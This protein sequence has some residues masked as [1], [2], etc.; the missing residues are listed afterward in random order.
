MGSSTGQQLVAAAESLYA[1][2]G[3]DG[4]SLRQIADECG[5]RNPAVV[6]YHFGSKVGLLRA[7]VERGVAPLNTRRLE[8]LATADSQGRGHDVHALLEAAFLPLIELEKPGSTY[9]RFLAQLASHP[10]LDEVFAGLPGELGVGVDVVRSRLEH[11]LVGLPEPLL[12]ARLSGVVDFVLHALASH[13][14]HADGA[15][16]AR[17]PDDLLAEDLIAVATGMLTA[18]APHRAEARLAEARSSDGAV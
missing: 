11:A 10:T 9:V 7:I 8:L 12:R 16:G 5:Q 1:E 14:R 4:V 3:I 6:Q 18:P 13:H 15:V 17:I 2:H